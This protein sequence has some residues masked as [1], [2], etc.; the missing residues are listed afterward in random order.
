MKLKSIVLSLALCLGTASVAQADTHDLG[1]VGAPDLMSSSITVFGAFTD[2]WSFDVAEPIFASGSLQ[3]LNISNL[4]VK[5]FDASSTLIVDL[6]SN[7][8]SNSILKVGSGTF[9]VADDYYFLV[10]GTGTGVNGKG[11]YV[12]TVNT[13]PVPEPETYAMF[14]A[15][16]GMLGVAARRRLK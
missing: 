8:D 16:L 14:L 3:S 11:K 6:S 12:F 15:G 5:L 10:S 13:L 4:S 1:I 7:P 9:P 2:M